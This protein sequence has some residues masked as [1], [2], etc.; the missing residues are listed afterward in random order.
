MKY[1]TML[2][3]LC[4]AVFAQDTMTMPDG[5]VMATA[6]SGSQYTGSEQ[7]QVVDNQPNCATHNCWLLTN[8]GSGGG[9]VSF[10]QISSG[11]NGYTLGLDGVGNLWN[12]PF[13]EAAT[14]KALWTKVTAL[15]TGLKGVAVRTS[16][17]VYA[18][19]SNSTCPT[20]Y[21]IKRW[22]GSSW[23]GVP[24]C[25]FTVS[26]T[27]DDTLV[28]IG[29]DHQIYYASNPL[30]PSWVGISAPNGGTWGNV[31]GQSSTVAFGNSGNV[32]YEIN[33]STGGL[34]IVSG[35]PAVSNTA[36][37][38]AVTSDN[39]LFVRSNT[40]GANGNIYAYSFGT[41]TGQWTNLPGN[42]TLLGG[43]VRFSLFSQDSSA[44]LYHYLA[45]ALQHVS[46]VN[47]YFDCGPNGCPAG[48]M[49]TATAYGHF[50][51][52][53]NT[54]QSSS[55][56]VTPSTYVAVIHADTSGLCDPIFG[57]PGSSDCF[58]SNNTYLQAQV[59]CSAMGQIFTNAWKSFSL[60]KFEIAYTRVAYTG[61]VR[62]NCSF[63]KLNRYWCD[64]PVMNWCTVNTTPPDS[65]Y[66]GKSVHD[67]SGFAYWETYSPCVSILG[68]PWMCL[69]DTKPLHL[70]GIA[71]GTNSALPY[72]YCTKN[73]P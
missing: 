64:Y 45:M 17:E 66:T 51:H 22:N 63:D 27:G 24:G 70:Y 49:H 28:V 61:A 7:Y 46:K 62:S 15:G 11:F 48:S 38:M 65:D 55:V 6:L 56:T 58:L 67:I 18:L 73:T 19:Y 2:M 47:G 59:A 9:A 4:S 1:L 39:Y 8:T 71:E 41:S 21:Q 12:L 54:A 3:L 20:A 33:L 30:N 52:G 14:G 57:D 40:A 5:T 42:T 44:Y 13:S 37:N 26:I 23:A 34:T 50:A 31:V 36:N 16:N 72:A 68:T 69:N 10:A 53:Y 25:A 32:L 35:A 43:S 29:A 60:N